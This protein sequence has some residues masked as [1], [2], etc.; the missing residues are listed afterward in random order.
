M[1]MHAKD[2]RVVHL[3]DF[4]VAN[5]WLEECPLF[6]GELDVAYVLALLQK[7]QITPDLIVENAKGVES[8]KTIR[9]RLI[10]MIKGEK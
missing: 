8:Y 5:D 1:Q 6:E 7:Y 9:S 2:I 4:T 3:K 10:T